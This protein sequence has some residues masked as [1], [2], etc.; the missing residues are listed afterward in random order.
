MPCT[1]A[2]E[3]DLIRLFDA[4]R[5][6]DAGTLCSPLCRQILEWSDWETAVAKAMYE[7]LR[8][9]ENV[10]RTAISTH[11][12]THYGRDDWWDSPRLRL[13]YGTREKIDAAERKLVDAGVLPT[14]EAIQ[15]EVPLGFWVSLL[16]RGM[17]YET[18]LW[19]PMTGAFP[20]YRD[21]R[22][23]LYM[24]MNHLRLLRN[25]VAHQDRIGGRRLVDDRRSVLTV[26]GYVSEA[27]ARRV[28]AA[29]TALPVLLTSRPGICSQ[30]G[31]DG[32]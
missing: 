22:Q 31:R 9:L 8:N 15:R 14:A 24:R 30:R 25:K 26:I 17:D 32:L 3:E 23:G 29:D 27:A 2:D 12:A 11:L 4:V 16:G 19:R 20:G 21:R 10:L 1:T 5:Y 28:D 7:L 13:T 18:Q 6:A